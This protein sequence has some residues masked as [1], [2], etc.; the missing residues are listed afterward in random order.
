M[1][2][3][4]ILYDDDQLVVI[5]KPAG[6]VVHPGAGETGV[7]I[8]DWLTKNYPAVKKETW[9][10]PERAGIVHRLDKDTSGIMIVAK[11][12]TALKGLQI[13]FKERTTKKVYTA[14]TVGEPPEIEGTVRTYIGRHPAKRQQQTAYELPLH[15]SAKEAVTDYR[16]E[17]VFPYQDVDIARV[18]FMPQTGR[19][20]QLRVHAKYLGTPILGDTVYSSKLGYGVTKALDAE[21]Q[22]LHA[23]SI[24]FVHPTL[25]T[26]L[27]F[28]APLAS[29]MNDVIKALKNS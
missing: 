8:V 16:V 4:G 26:Q 29:D 23:Q 9:E 28:T 10:E 11:T 6:V 20:H 18:T 21:R 5:N 24:S 14:L 12:V 19:M 1:T 15:H 13:Q 3:I 22:M 7:T 25:Q 2:D 17:E 27:M